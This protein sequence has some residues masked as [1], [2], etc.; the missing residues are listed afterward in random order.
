MEDSILQIVLW[1]LA[2]P[3]GFVLIVFLFFVVLVVKG[4]IAERRRLKKAKEEG[5][6]VSWGDV[7][8]PANRSDVTVFLYRGKKTSPEVWW[9]EASL[10]SVFNGGTDVLPQETDLHRDE[11]FME[12]LD[13]RIASPMKFAFYRTELPEDVMPH[14]TSE[15]KA[16]FIKKYPGARIA[17]IVASPWGRVGE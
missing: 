7:H 9:T 13:E 6:F 14:L 4:S 17:V 3:I 8:W 10:A 1:T 5:V 11:Q 15:V 2:I 12:S 16:E